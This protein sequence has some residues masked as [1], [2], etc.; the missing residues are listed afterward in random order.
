MALLY[1]AVL[2]STDA[3]AVFSTLRRLP[4]RPRLAAMLEAE[5]GINDAPAVLLVVAAVRCPRRSHLALVAAG[6][7]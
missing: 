6:R 4:V 1:G 5:S 2:S 3:A 7:C